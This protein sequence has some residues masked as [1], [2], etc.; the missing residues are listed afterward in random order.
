MSGHKIIPASIRLAI[1]EL[2]SPYGYS[3]DELLNNYSDSSKPKT[4]AKKFLTIAQ[5]EEY[6]ACGRW[7]LYRAARAG[8]ISTSKLSSARSG[9]ILIEKNTL[10][11]WLDTC[12][13]SANEKVELTSSRTRK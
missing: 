6:S 3:F 2:L 10:D 5:A 11:S 7:T 13:T 1:Q 4:M 9:K 12:R 8:K